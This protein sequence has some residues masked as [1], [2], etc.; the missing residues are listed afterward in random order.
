MKFE[1][2]VLDHNNL[3]EL[4]WQHAQQQAREAMALF[5]AAQW[6]RGPEQETVRQRAVE[7]AQASAETRRLWD[8]LAQQPY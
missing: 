7:M 4:L 5:C 8:C 6:L 2:S 3:L 1:L